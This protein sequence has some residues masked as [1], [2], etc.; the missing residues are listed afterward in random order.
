MRD[1]G[2]EETERLIRQ[3]E[4]RLNVVYSEA[5]EDVAHKLDDYMRR[6]E[7]KDRI[8][9]ERVAR[10]EVKASDYAEWRKSQIIVRRRWE[11]MKESLGKEWANTNAEARKI[12]QGYAKEAYAVNFNFATYEAEIGAGVD[13]SFTLYNREAVERIMRDNPDLLPEPSARINAAAAQKKIILWQEGQIQSVTLQSILQGESIPN[14]AK[15]IAMTLGELNHKDSIRYARTAM[16]GAQNAGRLDAYRRAEE[17]GI[18]LM[19]EWIATLDGRTR[20]EH[21]YLDGQKAKVNEPFDAEGVPIMYPGD[22][23]APGYLIWNCRCTM[24]ANV[25]GWESKSKAGRSLEALPKGTTY[26]QWKEDRNSKSRPIDY[27]EK[28]GEAIR[29]SY[30]NERYRRR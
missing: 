26:E 10:G 25:S 3:L 7:K 17:M 14:M 24:R 11:S 21:R 6:F 22:P 5:T 13:T 9:R 16:T 19:R 29:Q 23:S 28:V 27:Q 15:R 4:R 1:I 2:H 30:I 20:H 8:W 12:I 18:D